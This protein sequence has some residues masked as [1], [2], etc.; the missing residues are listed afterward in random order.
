[1]YIRLILSDSSF[2]IN[3]W[4]R[5]K[6]L[7]LVES[8]DKAFNYQSTLEFK[9]SAMEYGLPKELKNDKKIRFYS[10]D[11]K[12]LESKEFDLK[13]IE[14]DTETDLYFNER[15]F[16]KLMS[17]GI[18]CSHWI[19]DIDGEWIAFPKPED[20]EKAYR[21]RYYRRGLINV[22]SSHDN[23]GI[24]YNTNSWHPSY[25]GQHSLMLNPIIQQIYLTK[26]DSC[27]NYTILK[28]K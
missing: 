14:I 21:I 10:I 27:H 20:Y 11:S 23:W 2:Y 12:T 17:C 25:E 26:T 19:Y 28:Q 7:V 9:V 22:I 1:M 16:K 4:S 13:A 18:T 24:R 8:I 15:N 3:E 6:K 5:E